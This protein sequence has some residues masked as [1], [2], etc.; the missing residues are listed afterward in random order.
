LRTVMPQVKFTTDIIVGFPGETDEEFQQTLD[1]VRKAQFLMIHVFPYSKR[2][3]TPAASMNGQ[4]SESIKHQRTIKLIDLAAQIRR[5]MLQQI[6]SQKEERDVLFE[7]YANGYAYGHT[8]DFIEVAL[9]SENT[10]HAQILHVTLCCTDGNH[11]L[12]APITPIHME[13]KEG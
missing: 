4:V 1:F 6:V 2:Q 7:T 11:C 9:P 13:T 12:A 3:G 10:L 5:D 8:S